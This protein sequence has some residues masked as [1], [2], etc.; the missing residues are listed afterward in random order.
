V[1]AAP[2]GASYTVVTSA[3][4]N[5]IKGNQNSVAGD[6]GDLELPMTPFLSLTDNL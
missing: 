2:S 5:I 3:S 1:T 6:A 4:A